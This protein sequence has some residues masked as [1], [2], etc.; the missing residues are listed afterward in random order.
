MPNSSD[1]PPPPL[2][3]FVTLTLTAGELAYLTIAVDK[4][5]R[6]ES[7]SCQLDKVFEQLRKHPDQ[8]TLNV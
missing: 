1:T 4:D 5:P 6:L 8:A 7:V 3:Y 2:L